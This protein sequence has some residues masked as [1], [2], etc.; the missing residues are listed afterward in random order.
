MQR[1]EATDRPTRAAPPPGWHYDDDTGALM[2]D[3]IHRMGRRCRN[4]DYCGRGAYLVTMTLADRSQPLLGRIAGESPET[5]AF[6]PSPLGAAI[7]AHLRR[8]GDFTPEIEVLGAQLMPDHLHAVLRVNRRMAKPLGIAL[9]GFKGGASKIY[10]AHVGTCAAPG[11][12]RANEPCKTAPGARRANEPCAAAPGARRA[13]GEGLFADG[14][15]DN[16]LHDPT[17]IAQA[18][19]YVA[20]NPRRLWLKRAHPELFRVLRDVG[21]AGGRFAA[22]GNLALLKAPHIYQVQV[23]RSFFAYS[24]DARGAIL[25]DALPRIA[26]REFAEKRDGF[27]EA[28]AHGAVL[29]S[30]CISEGE[31]EIARLAFE[32]GLRVITLSNKGFSPLYKPGGKLFDATAAGNLLMLAPATWPYLPGE[33]KMTRID[34]CI[35]NRIAQ[36]LS[37]DGATEIKY[38]GV[39]PAEI[40]RLAA[41]A[42]CAAR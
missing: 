23:S 20:D 39:A 13:N 17:A 40:D 38:R 6:A 33:K 28:A 34:A 41:E 22:I 19:A 10:W 31:R 24:R 9:R 14:Y 3:V 42:I 37:G 27:L 25:K 1:E 35:L 30:P 18:L 2:R 7:D 32:K 5:A 15:V 8:I 16:I 4:W 21:A 29:L 12:R 11:A 26:T 36:W